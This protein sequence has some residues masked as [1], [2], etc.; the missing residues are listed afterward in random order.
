MNVSAVRSQ[1][2]CP[3]QW[4]LP[5]CIGNVHSW[6]ICLRL[7]TVGTAITY[8]A[9]PLAVLRLPPLVFRDY[10]CQRVLSLFHGLTKH[11]LVDEFCDLPQRIRNLR[12]QILRYAQ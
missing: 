6:L 1:A 4:T 10:R 7:R 11:V 3:N 9:S 8:V 2:H 5:S 12:A